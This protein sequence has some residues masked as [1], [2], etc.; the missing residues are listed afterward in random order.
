MI[1]I[2]A[3]SI[4]LHV[5]SS[6]A[7]TPTTVPL[8]LAAQSLPFSLFSSLTRPV[9]PPLAHPVYVNATLLHPYCPTI[10]PL[11]D[12]GQCY[13]PSMR[14]ELHMTSRNY[15]SAETS[16][17][18][19]D[20]YSHNPR[21]LPPRPRPPPKKKTFADK[22]KSMVKSV[23][24]TIKGVVNDTKSR[25][26][27]VNKNSK[28]YAGHAIESLDVHPHMFSLVTFRESSLPFFISGL[29]K[30]IDTV[31]GLLLQGL[32][33]RLVHGLKRATL[34]FGRISWNVA[35]TSKMKITSGTQAIITISKYPNLYAFVC[36]THL[37]QCTVSWSLCSASLGW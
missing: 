1:D 17:L 20:Y 24:Q 2:N 7:V 10:P 33:L 27:N 3:T 4:A 34:C 11:T 22:V 15:L 21:F 16:S 23:K 12:D 28:H 32:V 18:T 19:F 37:L 35:L 13:T 6:L 30:L 25:I 14:K 29:S 9:A 36:L 31:L 8:L 26:R 5:F